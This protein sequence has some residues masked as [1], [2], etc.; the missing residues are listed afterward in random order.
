MCEMIE[1]N[2]PKKEKRKPNGIQNIS[3]ENSCMKNV[4]RADNE[5]VEEMPWL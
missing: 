2:K 4:A 3:S 1:F 5:I